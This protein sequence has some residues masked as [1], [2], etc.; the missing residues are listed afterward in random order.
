LH[1]R[2]QTTFFVGMAVDW[3]NYFK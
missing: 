2:L 1:E 3:L